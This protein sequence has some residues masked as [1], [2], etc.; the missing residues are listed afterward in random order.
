MPNIGW[1]LKNNK[2]GIHSSDEFCNQL[3]EKHHVALVSGGSFGIE[4]NVRF[5]YA[6]SMDNLRKGVSRFAAFLEELRA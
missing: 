4:S 3:L 2:A 5:S 6:N 1:Y